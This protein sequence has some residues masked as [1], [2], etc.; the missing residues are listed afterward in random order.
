MK[1][2]VFKMCVVGA[3]LV[4]GVGMVSTM[5]TGRALG[6]W[7]KMAF[8]GF[9]VQEH[10]K[11]GEGC[12]VCVEALG[13][14]CKYNE[15]EQLNKP[16]AWGASTTICLQN[17]GQGKREVKVEEGAKKEDFP[18]WQKITIEL[19]QDCLGFLAECRQKR[20]N[21]QQRNSDVRH[22]WHRKGVTSLQSGCGPRSECTAK[23]IEANSEKC[24]T[25]KIPVVQP[26]A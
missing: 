16:C 9:E 12:Y 3:A 21:T 4:A 22:V 11:G 19:K 23:I 15:N 25:P 1:S 6:E 20:D 10:L 2:T 13:T 14:H 5:P 18:H 24:V 7:E 17:K 8:R 26:G